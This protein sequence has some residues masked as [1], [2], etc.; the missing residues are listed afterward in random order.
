MAT[1]KAQMIQSKYGKRRDSPKKV[2]G[3]MS[4]AFSIQTHTWSRVFGGS[5]PANP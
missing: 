3:F 4:S 5:F 2:R 1:I